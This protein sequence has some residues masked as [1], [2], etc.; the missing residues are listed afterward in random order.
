M[1]YINAFFDG[2]VNFMTALSEVFNRIPWAD[3]I[4]NL[5]AKIVAK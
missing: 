4:N 5:L 1:E 3:L 2:L